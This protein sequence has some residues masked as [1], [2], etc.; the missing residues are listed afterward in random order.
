MLGINVQIV[1]FVDGGQPG[2]VECQV[3]DARGRTWSFVERVPIVTTADLRV[4]GPYPHPGFIACE[5]IG[6]VGMFRVETS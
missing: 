3:V 5:E 1:R 2:F 6:A 4:E